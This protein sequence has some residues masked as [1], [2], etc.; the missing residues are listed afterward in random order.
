MLKDVSTEI[1][2][3]ELRRRL[4]NDLSGLESDVWLTSLDKQYKLVV[5]RYLNALKREEQ[6][7]GQG[8]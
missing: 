2:A 6:D 1:V 5:Y 3:M 4:G 7:D 8:R